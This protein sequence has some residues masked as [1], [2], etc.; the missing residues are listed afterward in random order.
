MLP[1]R[2]LPPHVPSRL[3][4]RQL[5]ESGRWGVPAHVTVFRLR[6]P[7]ILTRGGTDGKVSADVHAWPRFSPFMS[8]GRVCVC[9]RADKGWKLNQL[10]HKHPPPR[11][12][13]VRAR[14]SVYVTLFLFVCVCVCVCE[15]DKR[16]LGGGG[17][18]H[19]PSGTFSAS[20]CTARAVVSKTQ[21]DICMCSCKK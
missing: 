5:S 4:K 9:A 18:E 16:A 17:G 2:F 10:Q 11:C 15:F 8:P 20:C 6:C 1:L 12:V 21:F 14:V 19:W 7:R 3:F 13:C